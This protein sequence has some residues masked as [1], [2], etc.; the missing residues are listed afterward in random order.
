MLFANINKF[1]GEF[2]PKFRF[3]SSLDFL[4]FTFLLGNNQL[5]MSS[6]DAL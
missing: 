2:T 5:E 1:W 6:D 3:L 4:L